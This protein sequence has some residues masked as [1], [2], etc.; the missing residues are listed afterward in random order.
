MFWIIGAT[1]LVQALERMSD[2][3]FTRLLV[4]Q[5]KHVQWEGLHAYDLIFPLFLFL[6][7]V[8]IVLSLDKGL[9][10]GG[11]QQVLFRILRRSVL[12]YLL[13]IFY[14]GGLSHPWPDIQ[15]GGVLQR[16]ALCYFAAA[17]LYVTM[18]VRALGV[19]GAGLLVGYWGLLAFVPFPDLRLDKATVEPIAASIRS[20]SP[21]DIAAVP[22][23]VRGVYAEGY[24]LTNYVDFR[25]LPGKKTE[26]YYINEGLL[27][28]LPAI[29][30]CLGGI[31]AGR[32]LQDRRLGPRSKV[33]WLLAAGTAAVLLGYLWGLQF[34]LIKRIWSSSFVLVATGYSAI[35]LGVFY[36]VIDVWQWQRW[37]EPFV[38]IGTNALTIY[39]AVN[40]V[41]FPQLAER[42]VGGD[43]QRFLNEHVARG[44]GDLTVALAG[45]ALAVLLGWFLYRR[46]ISLRV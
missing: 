40:V 44:L 4:T 46:R 22:E 7:G 37:C 17:L 16:I 42:L 10:Q 34:P 13:G 41:R 39:L 8:S 26:I 21:A 27:S 20:E 19:V 31:G 33:T 11:K 24:N 36:L 2:N 30:L 23:R 25:F 29:A 28:T 43:V 45:L 9:A 15:L 1:A 3:P 32:L 38:W 6:V 14:Y 35:F 18:P 12:L 5:L